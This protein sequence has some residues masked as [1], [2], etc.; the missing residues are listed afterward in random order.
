MTSKSDVKRIHTMTSRTAQWTCMSRAASSLEDDPYYRSDDI[1][2]TK[3]I[4]LPV[5]TLLRTRIGRAV[6]RR[7][8]AARGMYE[9]VIARTRYMDAAFQKALDDRFEQI[10]FFGAGFDTRAVRFQSELGSTQVFELDVPITQAAKIE[11]YRQRGLAVPPNLK[12]VAIDF[13]K[14]SIPEKLS[15][16][17]FR[18]GERCLFILEGVLMYLLPAS[19]DSTFRTLEALGGKGSLVVFDY[20]RASVLRGDRTAYGEAAVT[21]AVDKVN[22]QWH[23]GLEPGQMESFLS[24]YGF[25]M[26]DHRNARGLEQLYFADTSGAIVGH[27][28]GT[29]GIV[30]AERS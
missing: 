2:A 21:R 5:L 16:F 19:V 23:F 7:C 1:I 11:R 15:Q 26:N 18:G 25:L 30:T 24:N 6:F 14:Q 13:D 4:P 17:G 9:Y 27:I 8:L 28:N 22:E 10:V 29:H 20:V 3:L 12:F